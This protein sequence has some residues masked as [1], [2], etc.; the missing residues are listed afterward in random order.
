MIYHRHQ[1]GDG[2]RPGCYPLWMRRRVTILCDCDE[3]EY[4]MALTMIMRRLQRRETHGELAVGKG[5]FAYRVE[6]DHGQETDNK[7]PEP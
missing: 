6:T 7:S 4:H 1:G 3:T 5:R 2:V